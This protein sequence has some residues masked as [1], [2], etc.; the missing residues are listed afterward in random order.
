M[1]NRSLSPPIPLP[2]EVGIAVLVLLLAAGSGLLAA[3]YGLV[4]VAAP[5]LVA[6]GVLLLIHPFIGMLLFVAAIPLE[7]ALMVGGRSVTALIAMGVFGAWAAQRLLRR[8]SLVPLVTPALVPVA[9]LL[10]SFACLSLIWAEY[11]DRM[12]RQLFLFFQLILLT[13]LVFDLASTWE[14]VAWLA[15][16]LVLAATF[17]ALLTLEQHFVGGVRRAGGG[18]VGGLNRTASTL[19]TILPLAFYLVRSNERPV[20]RMLGL[21]YIG[22]AG[23]AVAVT[24]SR[25][26]FLMLPLVVLVHVILMVRSRQGRPR[27]VLLAAAATLGLMLVPAD[28]V[29]DRAA[30]ILPYLSHSVAPEAADELYT[31]R[32][33]RIRVGIEMFKDYPVRGVGFDNYRPQFLNYQWTVPGF[34]PKRGVHATPTSPH[35]SHVGF[36]ANLGLVGISLWLTIFVVAFRYLR[37]TWRAQDPSDLSRAPLV[38]AVAI[39]VGLQFLFGFYGDVHQDK[40]LWLLLGLSVALWRLTRKEEDRT[41]GRGWYAPAVEATPTARPRVR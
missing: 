27:V 6:G 37:F 26:S 31:P 16:V 14:R 4:S 35:S 9:L 15:K 22:L 7:A 20:W 18:V 13:I 17:A 2:H 40:I 36:L 5:I 41:A 38:Q 21:G 28:I 3:G 19:V 10:L 1:A 11:P 30:T 12:P 33:Y 24:L 34:V 39:A 23:G 8:Q 29:R 25:M 32:G